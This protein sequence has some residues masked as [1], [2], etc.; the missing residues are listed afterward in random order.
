MVQLPHL[1][2]PLFQLSEP[3]PCQ[4]PH[5]HNLKYPTAT[6]LLYNMKQKFY[7]HQAAIQY[8]LRHDDNQPQPRPYQSC[9]H[10]RTRLNKRDI[11]HFNCEPRI[12]SEAYTSPLAM[13]LQY[14]CVLMEN[15]PSHANVH[16]V[17]CFT[18]SFWLGSLR[19]KSFTLKN[20]V[21]NSS[22]WWRRMNVMWCVYTWPERRKTFESLL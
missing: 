1:H 5:Q 15:I 14:I 8:H 10:T 22:T 12:I 11:P 16:S 20:I 9:N 3:P 13:G 4:R 7:H 2:L 21:S 19:R 6:D 18:C 17:I